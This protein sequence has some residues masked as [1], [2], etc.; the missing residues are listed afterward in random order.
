MRSYGLTGGIGSGK[1]TTGRIFSVLGIPLFLADVMAIRAYSI[2]RVKTRVSKL[3]GERAYKGEL[4][5]RKY[6]A[7]KV[8]NDAGL[9]QALNH[10][11]HP[12]VMLAYEDWKLERGS[13]PYVMLESAILFEAGLEGSFDG[14]IS[15]YAPPEVCIRRVMER[16]Q[17]SR[18]EVERRMQNQTDPEE[19][20]KRSDYRIINDG[21]HMLIPQVLAIHEILSKYREV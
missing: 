10:I 20:L 8:F 17:L 15:V 9:L 3:L 14:L 11:I 4:P 18:E 2:P 1:S 7:S 13:A 5:D 16:D 19:K 21:Q 12:E 6:I